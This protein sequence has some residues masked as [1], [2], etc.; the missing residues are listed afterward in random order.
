MKT[1]LS[2]NYTLHYTH[3]NAPNTPHYITQTAV[4]VDRQIGLGTT[5]HYSG[6][7]TSVQ[8]HQIVVV[9]EH[10]HGC[11]FRF[12]VERGASFWEPASNLLSNKSHG[13]HLDRRTKQDVS[14]IGIEE[15]VTQSS[16]YRGTSTT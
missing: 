12:V 7:Q 6:W 1:H 8:R 14:T 4:T 9:D 11:R 15:T 16:L 13:D 3:G 2:P 5:L 10:E